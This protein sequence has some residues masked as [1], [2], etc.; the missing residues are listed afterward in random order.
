MG[1][2]PVTDET[3]TKFVPDLV[4]WEGAISHMYRDQ[5][6][7][8]TVAIGY[9]LHDPDEAAGLPF[10]V[11]G[12]RL[13]TRAEIQAD[14]LRVI[15]LAKG[16]PAAKYRASGPPRVELSDASVAS[17]TIGRLRTEFMPGLSRLFIGFEELPHGPQRA[18]VDMAYNLGIGGLAQFG[19]LRAAVKARDWAGAAASCHVRTSR[20]ERNQWRAAKLLE[21]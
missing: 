5:L 21:A 11:G 18:L 15:A 3:L 2:R 9:L 8:I 13:A 7:Y 16:M 6:G 17:L 1:A 19:H 12:E 4:R 20:E 10:E 14:F